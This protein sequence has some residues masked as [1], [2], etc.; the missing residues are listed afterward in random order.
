[1][2]QCTS[3]LQIPNLGIRYKALFTLTLKLFYHTESFKPGSQIRQ[4]PPNIDPN[5]KID[6]NCMYFCGMMCLHIAF[7]SPWRCSH[8]TLK[9]VKK[10]KGTANK[11]GLK[12]LRVNKA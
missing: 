7:F 8:M 9:H 5:Q 3:T 10:I 12:T 4:I 2:K 11:N 6:I 1:M